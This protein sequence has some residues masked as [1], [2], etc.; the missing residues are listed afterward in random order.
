MGKLADHRFARRLV[1]IV[2]SRILERWDG[3]ELASVQSDE[4]GV[5]KVVAAH[6][7]LFR[8]QLNRLSGDCPEVRGC[9]SWQ[10]DLHL[11]ASALRA[12]FEGSG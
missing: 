12:L 3:R 9:C 5:D 7:N 4:C 8:Q 2:Q 6:N 10:D 11:D 1:R